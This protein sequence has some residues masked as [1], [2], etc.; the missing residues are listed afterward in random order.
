MEE[1]YQI[2]DYLPQRFK[3]PK[4]QEYI[5]FLWKSFESNYKEENY[6]FALMA[7]HMLFMSFVYFNVWQIKNNTEDDFQKSLIG[8]ADRIEKNFNNA[9]SPFTFSEEQEAK[10]FSFLKLIGV[11]KEKIGQYKKLVNDRNDIA[12]SNG[13]IYYQST[14]AIDQKIHDYLRFAEEIQSHSNDL[15]QGCFTKFLLESVDIEERE[16]PD[17]NDQINEIL[18]NEHY[19][20]QKDIQ[21]CASVDITKFE[22]YENSESIQNLY[23]K[24]KEDYIEEE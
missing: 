6:Q 11:G 18:I 15:I 21:F 14:D 13:N 16:Y 23:N 9:S 8:F 1:A 20:S 7:Y 5:E 19:L 4:E 2:L 22:G 12:H 24:L 10:I 3:N 17:D